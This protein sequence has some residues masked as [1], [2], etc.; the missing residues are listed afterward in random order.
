MLPYVHVNIY[1]M[2]YSTPSHNTSRPSPPISYAL[3]NLCSTINVTLRDR[4][5]FDNISRNLG[6]FPIDVF[7]AIDFW[8]SSLHTQRTQ[9]LFN[10]ICIKF[11]SGHAKQVLADM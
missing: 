2:Y 9:P 6:G 7:C 1:S 10:I 3:W 8:L 11:F 4:V 5:T